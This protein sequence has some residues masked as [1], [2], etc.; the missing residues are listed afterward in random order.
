MTNFVE[1]NGSY[2]LVFPFQL[3]QDKQIDGEGETSEVGALRIKLD[4]MGKSH[5]VVV[6]GFRSEERAKAYI[7]NVW[8]GL[9]WLILSR[10]L[11]LGFNP[12]P[13]EVVQ[14][15]NPS[16]A[17]ENLSA[18]VGLLNEGPVDYHLTSKGPAVLRTQTRYDWSEGGVATVVTSTPAVE[19][20]R[21][22]CE[23]VAFPR[24]E[25]VY[26]NEKLRLALELYATYFTEPSP[27]AKFLSLV[28]VLEALT[29][30]DERPKVVCDLLDEF[31]KR[32]KKLRSET[33]DRAVDR[34]LETLISKFHYEESIQDQIRN[35]IRQALISDDDVDR[36]VNLITPIYQCRSDL[37]HK[38][39]VE[40]SRLQEQTSNAQN[41]V[42]RVLIAKFIDAS[43]A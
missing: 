43:G 25:A 39:E 5:L 2:A 7:G 17:A 24:S 4:R 37:M 22:L 28:M 26:N 42:R 14:Y 16:E 36:L 29:E 13:Q 41:L 3:L 23:G 32:I 38:G 35:A 30:H 11:P 33:K 20:L 40:P 18:T 31:K 34:S 6:S 1:G 12:S 19:I 10:G 15:D 21:L 27:R 8:T 9:I